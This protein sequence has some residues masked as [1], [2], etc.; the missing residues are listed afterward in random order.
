MKAIWV[1]IVAFGV[2]RQS[3]DAQDSTRRKSYTDI[4]GKE[5]FQKNGL[6]KI[7]IVKEKCY[8]EIPKLLLGKDILIVTRISRGAD[9]AGN[10][11][12][13]P[14]DQV[15]NQV[16]RFELAYPNKLLLKKVLF[17]NYSGDSSAQM[18]NSVI[19][20]TFLP[21]LAAFPI[22][23]FNKDSTALVVDMTSYILGDNEIFSFP[24]QKG[25][26]SFNSLATDKSFISEIKS[27]PLNVEVTTVKTFVKQIT[28]VGVPANNNVS[29][30]FNTSIVLLPEEL[31]QQRFSDMRVGYFSLS[32]TDYDANPNGI[33]PRIYIKRWRLE[34]KP[35]DV[36]K[37]KKGI[38]VEPQKPIVF[39]IDP[40]TPK[41]WIPYL[42]Q[43]VK[44]WQVA[45]EQAGFKNAIIAK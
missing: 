21:I 32:Q 39:Y 29:F 26:F 12:M 45:F 10:S 42:M 19:R 30:E 4:I 27:F 38:L 17:T 33:K 34:P 31:M 35:E 24:Y 37:Y 20:S 5:D 11:T 1:F 43:G 6:F 16:A 36:E 25:L 23:T 44:D 41:K 22:E 15:S 2:L 7:H 18:Y 3:C 40:A 9:Q 14:G 28:E 13:Y 8:F